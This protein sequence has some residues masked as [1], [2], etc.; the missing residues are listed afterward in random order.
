MSR[1]FTLVLLGVVLVAVLGVRKPQSL[2]SKQKEEGF[3]KYVEAVSLLGQL[4]S[5]G[6]APFGEVAPGALAAAHAQKEKLAPEGGAWRPL[7]T[8]PMR[9]DDP[10]Y[11]ISR[12][13]HGTLSGRVTAFAHDP[14]TQG[15]H[16]LAAAAGGVFET[17]DAGETWRSIGDNLPTQVMGALG[18]SAASK[19]LVAGTGDRAFGGSSHAGLGIYRSTNNGRGW[20]KSKGVPDEILSFRIAFDPSDSSGKTVYAA[21]S[22]G[23]FRSVDAAATF[24]NVNLPTGACAGD[25]TSQRCFFANI[26][27]DVVVRARE[28]KVM[29]A[30]G[31]RAGRAKNKGD[32]AVQS[33]HNGIYVS[34]SGRPGTFRFIDAGENVSTNGFA[35]NR[36]VGRVALGAAHGPG[37]NPDIVYAIVQDAEK[38][39]GCVDVLD[40]NPLCEP[41]VGAVTQGTVLDAAYVTRDFGQTWTKIMDWTQLREPGTNSSL[42]GVSASPTYAPGIQ[43][44]YNLWIA[45]DP[46][47]TDATSGAPARVLFGLEEVWENTV[48]IGVTGPAQWKVIGRYWN[49]CFGGVTVTAGLQC[50]D[51]TQ[52]IDAGTTTH[53]DQQAVLFAP[54]GLGGVTVFVGNDGGVYKQHVSALEDFDN[55]S[56]GKGA[57]VGL[58]TLQAYDAAIAKDGTTT[59]GLQDNG[60]VKIEAGTRRAVAIF[61]GDGF[62]S[63]IDPDDSARIVE[64]YAGG[65]V[66]ITVDGG[67]NWR[68]I[69]PVLTA[70]L[71]WTPL[72]VDPTDANHFVIAGRDVKER[73]D[74][75]GAGT[76]WTTLFDLGTAASG[77]DRQASALDVRGDVVYAAFCGYCDVITQNVPFARGIATNVDGAWRF[78]AAA[79]LPVRYITSIRMDPFDARTIFVTLGGYG[80]RW[81][82]PGMAGEDTSL[83]GEGHVFK[84]TDAGE[85]FVDISGNLPDVPANWSLV[86]EGRLVVATDIGVFISSD[87]SGGT[88]SVLG[89]GLPHAPVFKV[90]L[91]PGDESHLL[92][93]TY[94]RG[95]YSYR[96]AP[97]PPVTSTAAQGPIAGAVVTTVATADAGPVTRPITAA[98][99]EFDV[100]SGFDNARLII[101]ATHSSTADIDLYLQ[102]RQPDGSYADA[103][104]SITFRL[105]GESLQFSAPPA[106]HYRLLVDEYLGPPLLNVNLKV[107]F[108]NA[109]NLPGT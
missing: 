79:G 7:G 43:S 57:N 105:D 96:F 26:V 49:A 70:P 109:Q 92:A 90:R 88:Y 71:F 41:T 37:Q 39:A 54:D 52:P 67:R 75:Y 14:A 27:T 29:A 100:L 47:V 58:N 69:D 22:K 102:Q 5:R 3:K 42:G 86:R 15:H 1:R 53:P 80:R 40:V 106:G 81:V 16:F 6:A 89:R 63:G 62:D 99:W 56:W 65:V 84:S 12:L 55:E 107:T 32:A 64:E 98:T 85:T 76:A 30:V 24:V 95:V 2:P 108:Y 50:N 34:D 104:S 77:A 97:P 51:P 82:P 28:G 94:G 36:I 23:L 73:R 61:G 91:Q 66:S 103:A 68:D 83:V 8:T 21:T 10:T 74:G 33:P 87:A 45:P 101:D 59:A 18:Y 9:T 20:K 93:V 72:V 38:F 19:V 17:T 60:Q 11:A 25:T 4:R 13:G 31:W 48:R 78:A 46:T 44:W 35:I